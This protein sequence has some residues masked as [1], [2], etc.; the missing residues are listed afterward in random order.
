MK[1]TNLDRVPVLAGEGVHGLLLEALLALGESLVP[2]ARVSI[3]SFDRKRGRD[4][5]FPTAMIAGYSVEPLEERCWL[6]D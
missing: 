5:H 2:V 1:T 6:R 3:I 4:A